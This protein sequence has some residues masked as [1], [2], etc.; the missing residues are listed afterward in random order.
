MIIL[1]GRYYRTLWQK[2]NLRP[3]HSF[4]EMH[5]QQWLC[6]KPGFFSSG[7]TFL[8]VTGNSKGKDG[9]LFRSSREARGRVVL[10]DSL[11]WRLGCVYPVPWTVCPTMWQS[12]FCHLD[13]ILEKTNLRGKFDFGSSFGVLVHG[14]L[15]LLHRACGN[16]VPHGR[17]TWQ[18]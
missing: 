11:R 17:N 12:D 10:R 16:V 18:R 1:R 13:K 9:Q 8:D 5:W 4:S 14:H 3:K 15:C 7:H 6:S 2:G